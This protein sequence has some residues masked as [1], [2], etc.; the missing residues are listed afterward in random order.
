VLLTV[1]I[2]AILTLVLAKP[3]LGGI[4]MPDWLE[5]P[6]GVQLPFDVPKR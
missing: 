6:R 5:E 4:P 2:L 1:P 3:D